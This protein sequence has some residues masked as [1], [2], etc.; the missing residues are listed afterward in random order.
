VT[1]TTKV[2]VMARE[3]V[4]ESD[5]PFWAEHRS[6]Y[7]FAAPYAV[8][9]TV[10]DIACGAGYGCLLLKQKGALA[11]VGVDLSWQAM[12]DAA[13]TLAP[14]IRLVQADGTVL[15]LASASIDVITSFETLE[16][17]H[18]DSAF[19][20]E[21][22]RVLRPDGLLIL[23]TPNALISKPVNGVPNNPFHV[24][25]FTP[26]ELRDVL[27]KHFAGVELRGQRVSERFRPCPYWEGPEPPEKS[28]KTMMKASAWKLIARMPSTIQHSVSRSLLGH[29]LYPGEHDFVFE[30]GLTNSAHVLLA[31]C[32]C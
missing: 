11:V 5:S 30:A 15:P 2:P 1:S 24:R 23:S 28:A 9:R 20:G 3:R 29:E 26:D 21:L 10:L 13:P 12:A 6:R 18:D 25:E 14:G 4:V 27:Q 8:G 31:L 16:H 32:R 17:I 7:H 19:L 22:H